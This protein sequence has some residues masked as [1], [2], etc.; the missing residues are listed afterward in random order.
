M[1]EHGDKRREFSMKMAVLELAA[2]AM[3]YEVTR[4]RG[5]VSPEANVAEGGHRRSCHLFGL[6][7]DINL[8]LDGNYIKDKTGHEQL[9]DIWDIMGGAR[10][11]HKDMN[12]YSFEWQ[13]VI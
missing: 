3:G 10:R 5:Y 1:S 2:I 8:Y 9:H 6:A 7:Q 12:H 4:G 11:I 13:G